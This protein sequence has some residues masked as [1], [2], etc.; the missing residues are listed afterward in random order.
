MS[1]EKIKLSI[2][3]PILNEA[4][5]IE[6]LLLNVKK[7]IQSINAITEFEIIAVDDGSR[8]DTLI[9]LSNIS[10]KF[11]EIT[12]VKHSSTQGYGRA[13]LSGIKQAN[14]EWA[15]IMDADGQ[16]NIKSINRLLP[17]INSYNIITGVRINRKDP[18]FRLVIGK[19]YNYIA[20]KIYNLKLKDIN[21]GFKLINIRK[22][23]HWPDCHSGLF[24]AKLFYQN[25]SQNLA[26]KQ[27]P[28][29]HYPRVSGNASGASFKV[30]C[31][32][33]KDLLSYKTK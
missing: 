4:E 33:I 3:L 2:L 23:R 12:I 10:S 1:K 31:R 6:S 22:V 19:I 16:F 15:L 20:S 7:H 11:D 32:S 18:L 9:K 17:H 27:V 21:C 14:Y 29:L 28:I 8:D 13:I 25:M 5:H 26:I 24:Y 30:I